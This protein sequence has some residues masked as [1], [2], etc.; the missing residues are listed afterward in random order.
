M[1]YLH[2]KHAKIRN[3]KQLKKFLADIPDSIPV[4]GFLNNEPILIALCKAQ[5]GA[6]VF[7]RLSPIRKVQITDYKIP[8]RY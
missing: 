7:D 2:E 5:K 8:N 3:V 4:R 1:L 6:S